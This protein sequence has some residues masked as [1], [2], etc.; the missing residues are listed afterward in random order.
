MK[1]FKIGQV[2]YLTTD[3]D[4]EK[5]IVTAIIERQTGYEY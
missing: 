3:K 4:Q 5:R 2:V 1:R